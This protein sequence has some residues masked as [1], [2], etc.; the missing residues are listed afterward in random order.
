MSNCVVFYEG[1][2][3]ECCGIP[4]K[5]GDSIE[6]LVKK[7]KTGDAGLPVDIGIIDYYYEAHTSEYKMLSVLRGTVTEI[8][9]L[10]MKYERP[11][12]KP[13]NSS[14]RVPVSGIIVNVEK[15]AGWDEPVEKGLIFS[16]YIV[17]LEN[18]YVRPAKKSEVTFS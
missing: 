12:E 3:M 2:Q 9:A 17:N 16:D 7:S 13:E 11:S 18:V 14:Y 10:H 1:W 8:R 15:A 4:F 5:I 6:W